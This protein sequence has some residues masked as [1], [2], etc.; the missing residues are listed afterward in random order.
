V[1]TSI[2]ACTSKVHCRPTLPTAT[3]WH[4]AACQTPPQ[5][6][7]VNLAGHLAA[8]RLARSLCSGSFA[9]RPTLHVSGLPAVQF[10]GFIL[11]AT[12]D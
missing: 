6:T 9:L 12:R 2:T 1:Y 3:A 8:L 10:P 7:A 4:R 11:Q 5:Y